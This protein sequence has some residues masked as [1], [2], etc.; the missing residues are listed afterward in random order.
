[1]SKITAHKKIYE[2]AKKVYEDKKSKNNALDEAEKFGMDRG[3]MNGYISAFKSMMEGEEYKRTINDDAT[4]YYLENIL[5]DFGQSKLLTAINALEKHIKYYESI[6][7]TKRPGLRKI[8]QKFKEKLDFE[9]T[10]YPDEVKD[11]DLFEGTAK[12]ITVNAYE[13]NSKARIECI[14]EYGYKCTICNFD[15]EKIYGEIGRNFIHVHHI[16]PLAEIGEKYNIDPIKDLRPVCPNCH[17]MLHK[18]KSAYSIKEIT[19]LI[20]NKYL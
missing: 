5:K 17:A 16:K 20:D 6:G 14:K 11:N 1:M 15:F 18:R 4:V 19:N 2:L 3:T 10:V 13:R 7:S 8:L 9:N 12:Q